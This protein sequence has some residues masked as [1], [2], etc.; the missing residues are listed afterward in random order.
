MRSNLRRNGFTLIELLVV[1][2][3]LA[4]M[5]S[6]IVMKLGDVYE[7]SR[8]ATQAYSLADVTRQLEIFYGLNHK[9]PDGFDTLLLKGAT[10]A[11]PHAGPYTKIGPEL[12]APSTLI[13]A[14]LVT[15]TADQRTSINL[16]GISHAF[17][18][19]A[20]SGVV[21]SDSGVER[22]HYGDP[23]VLG[24]DGTSNISDAVVIDKGLGTE[25]LKVLAN[26]FGLAANQTVDL[27][28]TVPTR[29][30]AN[31]YIVLGL[32]RKCTLNGSQIMETPFLEQTNSA[33]LYSR[34]LLVYEVPNTG[35]ARAKLVGVIG[36]DGRTRSMSAGD[37][38]TG[39]TAH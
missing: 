9:Y 25:G 6:L 4:L 30:A 11:D 34:A 32:G 27:S 37:Y 15:L 8:S 13:A 17:L 38:F 31:T 1:L 36:P 26:D 24:H 29:I 33:S 19:D 10:S 12:K 16:A 3:I 39:V 28:V 21:P 23:L 5:S 22:H 18:H 2:G 35:T 20:A 14:S 7:R